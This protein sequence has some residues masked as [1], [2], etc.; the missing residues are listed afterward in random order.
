MWTLPAAV[1]PGL[2]DVDLPE[3]NCP[4]QSPSIHCLVLA[5]RAMAAEPDPRQALWIL[6][7]AVQEDL[8][9]DRAGVFAFDRH[10]RTLDRITG[11]DNGGRIEHEGQCLN[12]D[13]LVGPH[14]EVARRELPFYFTDDAQRD[15]PDVKFDP[16]VRAHV[17]L[18]IITGDEL[19]GTLCVDNCLSG[20]PISEQV[21]EPLFMAAALAALPLLAIYQKQERERVGR[22]RRHIYRE[23]IS[24]ATGGKVRLC[25]R[26]E[27]AAEWP[28]LTNP[29]AIEREADVR[30]ARE[31]AR[32]V[33]IAAEMAEE[34]AWDLGL[35][36]SEAATNAL[37]HGGGGS[38]VAAVRDGKIRVRVQDWGRGIPL[39]RLPDSALRTGFSCGDQP[40]M[41]CGFTLMHE[42]AD[43]VY[44]YSGSDGTTVIIEMSL[45]PVESLPGQWDEL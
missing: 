12:V 32:N 30:V 23:V 28:P 24:A 25:E 34:R 38:S 1:S 21:L 26:D 41:G 17:I 4:N 20:R 15:Y 27:I 39:E 19:L 13:T 9:I 42:M 36:V 11:V 31:A 22:M 29:I 7:R 18:P 43:G 14:A 33:G 16:R 8:G 37:V 45:S 35:C 2:M 10:A 3:P 5:S 40:S 6:V 44:L